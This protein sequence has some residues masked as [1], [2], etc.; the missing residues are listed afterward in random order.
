MGGH[1][2]SI[3]GN[4]RPP[5][6]RRPPSSSGCERDHWIDSVSDDGDIIKLED[7]SVWEVDDAGTVTSALWL[8]VTDVVV[9][10]AKGKMINTDDNVSVA[11]RRLK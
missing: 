2:E 7:G 3:P 10:E 9:C 6:A 5:P 4:R 1:A 8:P 11:I